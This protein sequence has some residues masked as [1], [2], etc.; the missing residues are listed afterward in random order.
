MCKQSANT[1]T[2][3][4]NPTIP[5]WLSS[6]FQTLAGRAQT[7]SDRPYNPQV[8]RNV[9]DFTPDQLQAFSQVRQDQGIY[10]PYTDA[11]TGFAQIGGLPISAGQIA[12]YSNPFQSQVIDATM[13]NIQQ[14]NALQQANLKGNAAIQGGL[15]N[16]RLGLAQAELA[17][18]QNLATN[19]TLATL[20][21]Q[22]YNQALGA[23]QQDRS[24][25]QQAASQFANL[26]SNIQS[27]ANRDAAALLQTGG[28]QQG[29]AQ[30]QFDTTSANVAQQE[31]YPFATTSW[32]G[33]M[34]QGASPSFTGSQQTSTTPGPSA[35][36]QIAGL[37]MLGYGLLGSDPR[38]KIDLGVVGK[39][40]DGTPVHAFK[41]KDDPEGET[42][43]GPMADDVAKA[44][45][46]A[47]YD[48]DGILY[49]KPDEVI[50]RQ[51]E[52]IEGEYEDVTEREGFNSGG[53]TAPGTYSVDKNNIIRM[54]GQAGQPTP[55]GSSNTVPQQSMTT[56]AMLQAAP[57]KKLPAPKSRSGQMYDE[58]KDI[59]DDMRGMQQAGQ[60]LAGIADQGMRGLGG[61][62]MKPFQSYG[63]PVPE[64][65]ASGGRVG[66]NMG[67]PVYG[68]VAGPGNEMIPGTPYYTGSA[69]PYAQFGSYVPPSPNPAVRPQRA[70]AL[71]PAGLGAA[72]GSFR[73]AQEEA[74]IPTGAAPGSFRGAQEAGLGAMGAAAPSD[75]GQTVAGAQGS[76]SLLGGAMSDPIRQAMVQAGLATLGGTSPHAMVNIGRGGQV[77]MGAYQQAIALEQRKAQEALQNRIAEEKLRMMTEEFK[78]RQAEFSA[79]QDQR[80]Y[81][82]ERQARMDAKA[83]A[84]PGFER[85]QEIERE[86]A[87]KRVE[88]EREI[89]RREAIEAG[90]GPETPE[91]KAHVFGMK[92]ATTARNI[93][94]ANGKF[95]EVLPDG[96][97]KQVLDTTQEPKDKAAQGI[98]GGLGT[99]AKIPSE[100]DAFEA[101]VGGWRGDPNSTILG[102]IA[103]AWGTFSP[104]NW[105]N[106][107]NA[108]EV[109]KRILADQEALAAVIKP[110]I[111]G[112]GEGAWTDA[113]QARLVG[114]V[115]DLTTA[116]DKEDYMRRLDG[117]RQRIESNFGI[118]LPPIG[119]VGAGE[120]KQTKTFDNVDG[121][122]DGA[123]VKDETGRR[124]IKRN[125]K[126]EPV[127]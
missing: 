79:Q 76:N 111:R 71:P 95:Y 78:Q 61:V 29:L 10:Q 11:A 77:G 56:G 23:S 99:L 60:G 91:Y 37:G 19:Q 57:I 38:L 125:G 13:A 44:D 124:F 39:L 88:A 53:Y 104:A 45:P 100:M 26:G 4:Q 115:G 1:Q 36:S 74:G 66:Y 12:N 63:P 25:A 70:P 24:A 20:N 40:N 105:W 50:E 73:G 117:V 22:N 43:F 42:R 94:E 108:D 119:K 30:T 35:L 80:V 118:K 90:Y 96:S 102:G 51:T 83:L 123:T 28:L 82:R 34:L 109:R 84:E 46:E 101:A 32:L 116:R 31:Q 68:G 121:I 2:V 49:I 27:M 6:Q 93:K 107:T 16:D 8:Q 127:N 75:A 15:G 89:K 54:S 7:V 59:A 113:D 41:Y 52:V 55:Y 67:G 114:I 47:V 9:A 120:G 3:V 122:P 103:R 92:S 69:G 33:G 97:M 64:G 87:I 62:S 86:Q 85:R 112:P 98:A 65:L 5:D 18:N 126:L 21:A 110:L 14:N 106:T 48:V 72:A 81:D 58:A 17:R